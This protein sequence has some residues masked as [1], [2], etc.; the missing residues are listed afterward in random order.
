MYIHV[1]NENQESYMPSC[2]KK[3][4]FRDLHFHVSRT[5][6]GLMFQRSLVSMKRTSVH[7]WPGTCERGTS[8]E[9]S[10]TASAGRP[11]KRRKHVSF[12]D[13]DCATCVY[14]YIFNDLYLS[15][16][17]I[18]TYIYMI[19]IHIYRYIHMSE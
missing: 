1:K 8:K 3:P 4:R 2:L 17:N 12:G 16:F 7:T 13:L 10:G 14:I 19:C 6:C 5:H 18:G 15:V 11:A 9:L